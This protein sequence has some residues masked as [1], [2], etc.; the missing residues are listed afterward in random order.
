MATLKANLAKAQRALEAA[1]SGLEHAKDTHRACLV[2]G[3]SFDRSLLELANASVIAARERYDLASGEL[4][5]AVAENI[6]KAAKAHVR[7]LNSAIEKIL[8]KHP[9][10]A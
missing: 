8:T 10:D 9:E 6:E 4:H 1:E 7:L 5:G 2:S 3:A